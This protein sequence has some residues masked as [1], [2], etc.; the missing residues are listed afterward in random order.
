M[1]SFNLSPDEKEFTATFAGRLDTHAIQKM[2]EILQINLPVT[3]GAQGMKI[4]FDLKDVVYVSSSFI[5]ICVKVAKQAGIGKFSIVHCQPF[6]L[7]TFQLSG[8]DEILNVS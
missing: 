7:K 8:L 3:E 4:I 6:I 5:R 2:S 1:V